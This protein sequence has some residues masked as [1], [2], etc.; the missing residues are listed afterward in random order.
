MWSLRR[1]CHFPGVWWSTNSVSVLWGRESRGAGGRPSESALAWEPARNQGWC[2]RLEFL[3]KWSIRLPPVHLGKARA[4]QLWARATRQF[5]GLSVS[6]CCA[7]TALKWYLSPA[8]LPMFLGPH[9]VKDKFMFSRPPCD[10]A[11][12]FLVPCNMNVL[13]F[14][15]SNKNIMLKPEDLRLYK[16]NQYK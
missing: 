10:K 4:S 3:L 1:D 14:H 12:L 16:W 2:S 13:N 5:W 15:D 8:L 9:L 7:K 11:F 6:S